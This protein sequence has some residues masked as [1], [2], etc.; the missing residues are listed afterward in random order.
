MSIKISLVCILKKHG[1]GT[2]TSNSK[3][4]LPNIARIQCFLVLVSMQ[5]VHLLTFLFLLLDKTNINKTT[6]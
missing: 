3:Y 2:P 6:L 5:S 4:E 1:Y